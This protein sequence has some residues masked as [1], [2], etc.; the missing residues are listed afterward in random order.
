M[1]QIY[2]QEATLLRSL[3]K[4]IQ[5]LKNSL[6]N[7]YEL[8]VINNYSTSLLKG[9]EYIK[10]IFMKNMKNVHDTPYQIHI[11]SLHQVNMLKIELL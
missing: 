4:T 8:Y 7:S 10:I 6:N 9:N 2:I 5:K 11:F 1:S 3:L